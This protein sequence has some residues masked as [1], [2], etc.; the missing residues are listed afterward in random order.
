MA[1]LMLFSATEND[2]FAKQL[3]Q[4]MGIELSP[5]KYKSF[6]GA[7]PGGEE[8]LPEVMCNVSG[9]TAVVVWSVG[10][11]NYELVQ[12]CQL[13]DAL[14]SAGEAKKVILAVPCYPY[15][16][17]DKRHGRRESITAQLT[18]RILEASSMDSI[19]Y[20]DIH[21][22]QIEG[23][24][25]KAIARGLWMDEILMHYLPARLE[26]I[27]RNLGL[28]VDKIRSMSLDEGSVNLNYRVARKLEHIMA[29]HIKK[30]NW[31]SRHSVQ[32][33]GIAG[34]LEGCVVYSR[35]DLLA[36]G[37]SGI[38]GAAEAKARGAKYVI[39]VITHG[40]G[41]DKP[42]EIKDGKE[43]IHKGF[44][45]KLNDSAIDE[46]VVTNSVSAFVKR[47]IVDPEL[48]KKVSILDVTPFFATVLARN[49]KGST[50]REMMVDVKPENLYKVLFESEQARKMR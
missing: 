47:V 21:A 13:I 15:A 43:V 30:R 37:D 1:E 4:T 45:E 27:L 31:D 20:V 49:N 50:I 39:E 8:T 34:S 46:L 28:T 35:D 17:Q 22:D 19:V 7:V 42:S 10:K 29:V 36:S 9:R 48:Q 33:L 14:K 11:T 40:L 32:S 6:L 38:T 26:G 44:I 16:R 24:F 2:G 23:F 18:A 12:V 3:A 25:R 5:V 41:F